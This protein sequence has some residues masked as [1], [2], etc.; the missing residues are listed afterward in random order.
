[1]AE[2]NGQWRLDMGAAVV[3]EGV[4]FRVWAPTAQ[5]VDV[6]ILTGA[7]SQH[8][9]MASVGDGLW[10]TIVRRISPG[11]RYRY[12]LNGRASFPDPCS[13]SQPEGV[14]GPS[15]VIDPDSYQWHDQDWRGLDIRGLVIYEC[16][17]G[18]FTPAGTFE[19]MIPELD[20][21]VRL[22]VNAIELMPVAAFSGRR[23]WGYDGV[24]PY[25]PTANYG[26]PNGL[27]R[28]VDAAHQRGLGVIMDVVYNHLGPEGNYLSQ[29]S[30]YYF[31]DRYH[32]PW[33]DA[34][35]YD[36]PNSHW[37]RKYVI[38]NAC[39]WVN[40]YHIDGLRLDATF[41]IYDSS[42]PHV[43]EELTQAVRSTVAGDRRVVLIAETSENNVRYLLPYEQG[44]FA[45]DAIWADD[46]HHS[47][48]RYL[49][50]DHEG[51][52]EDYE[53]TLS[54]VART[55]NQGFLYEGAYSRFLGTQRGT[56]AR[57][58]PAWQFQYCIQ[59]HD[60]V[61]NRA[62]GD[63]LHHSLDL[64]RYRVASA[65][66][67]LLPYTPLLFMGQ[68]FAASSPF[69][70]FT[71]HNPDLGRLVTEGRRN[72]FKHYS[73]FANPET[74]KLIPDPQAEETFLRSKLD[75]SEATRSPGAEV[76][77]LYEELLRLRRNDAVLSAQNRH[78]MRARA[79]TDDLL[80]VHSWQ[81]DEHRLLLAN[82]GAEGWVNLAAISDSKVHNA[83]L[84][85]DTDDEQFGGQGSRTAIESGQVRIPARS[86]VLLATP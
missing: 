58:Q 5:Q 44:G 79:V 47:L 23:N 84:L 78:A 6:E 32:T 24:Y 1:M 30:P 39:Y 26:G 53:G 34:I 19:S 40:E 10:E 43:L 74:A 16:H 67:L 20:R 12:R 83:R 38:D 69:L 54:E 31:T 9:S 66:L 60:Q 63:R 15:E 80:V 35:N 48:R 8:F 62:M 11:T 73:A 51:Y 75:L 61:G 4:R 3:P 50:G 57:E 71:D 17:I 52:Y 64:D 55:I 13:R 42:E 2:S 36:G 56:P 59:T 41:K 28:L 76:H 46:F 18:T 81:G 70:Y 72:E 86:A 77:R 85:I 65:L 25:A 27:K 29:F 7:A 14:H 82:F 68:E 45:F 37:V 21:L 22:G 33:G 49:L